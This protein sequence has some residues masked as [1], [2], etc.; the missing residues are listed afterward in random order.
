M[1]ADSD[2]GAGGLAFGLLGPLQVLR[3]GHALVLGGTRQRSVLARLLVDAD[4]VVSSSALADA[5][6]REAT[7]GGHATTLQTYVFHLREILEP[8]RVR[9][10]TAEVLVTEPGGYRLVVRNSRVDASRFEDLVADGR[11]RLLHD[12]YAGA[13]EQLSEALALWRGPVLADLAD[14]E[15]VAPLSGRLEE[16]RLDAT[17]ARLEALL[18]LGRQAEVATEASD[19]IAQHSSRRACAAAIPSTRRREL[20]AVIACRHAFAEARS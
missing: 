15:F 16:L 18:G 5:L 3:D 2:S 20:V 14:L 9:G 17:E 8:D 10:A 13:S 6:W 4:H 12:D 1:G 7:P 11:Q 19:L